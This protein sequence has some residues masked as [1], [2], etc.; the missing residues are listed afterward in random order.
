MYANACQLVKVSINP[1]VLI[2]KL[3]VINKDISQAKLCEDVCLEQTSDESEEI[4]ENQSILEHQKHTHTH[5]NRM[6]SKGELNL[7]SKCKLTLDSK[8]E[9]T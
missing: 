3:C 5:K 1:K 6:H 9:L 8:G 4:L 2:V 7:D